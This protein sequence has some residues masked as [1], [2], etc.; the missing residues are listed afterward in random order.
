RPSLAGSL[1]TTS[2]RKDTGYRLA[3]SERL[4]VAQIG[5]ALLECVDAVLP[6]AMA[7]ELWRLR[8][9]ANLEQEQVDPQ[10]LV[11]G[12]RPGLEPSA[13]AA[14]GPELDRP[15]VL[16]ASAGHGRGKLANHVLG[17]VG[18]F[19]RHYAVAHP[20]DVGSPSCSQDQNAPSGIEPGKPIWILRRTLPDYQR[21][22]PTHLVEE[23][24]VLWFDGKARERAHRHQARPLSG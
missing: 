1:S 13:R 10:M 22:M 18:E 8:P 23:R 7:V 15:P 2:G 17:V 4:T 3:S 6:G 20:V 11:S 5:I 24:E 9:V 19:V 12:L 14:V 16:I 21:V